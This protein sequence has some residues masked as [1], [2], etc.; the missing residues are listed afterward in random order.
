MFGGFAV[1]G[2][3]DERFGEEGIDKLSE[4]VLQIAEGEFFSEHGRGCC[5]RV[6][7]LFLLFSEAQNIFEFVEVL[8][9]PS[10][11]FG[12]SGDV[13]E[14]SEESEGVG[15]GFERGHINFCKEKERT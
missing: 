6:L 14:E 1:G 10:F 8:L 13:G 9:C 15:S 3:G 5:R 7:L 12:G 11:D 2:S 4:S